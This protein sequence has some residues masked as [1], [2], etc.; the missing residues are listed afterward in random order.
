MVFESGVVSDWGAV[1]GV[2]GDGDAA[3]VQEELGGRE[4]LQ[5]HLDLDSAEILVTLS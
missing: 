5:R 1:D 2:V 4:L 3:E